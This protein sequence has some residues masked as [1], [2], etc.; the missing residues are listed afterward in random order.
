MNS[1]KLTEISSDEE[2]K[3]RRHAVSI[4]TNK[5]IR[6]ADGI[7]I[8]QKMGKIIEKYNLHEHFLNYDLSTLTITGIEQ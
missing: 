5:K 4:L 1:G 6:D 2:N 3:M 8:D 7:P